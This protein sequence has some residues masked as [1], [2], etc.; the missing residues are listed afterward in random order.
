MFG[1]AYPKLNSARVRTHGLN[2]HI[3][4]ASSQLNVMQIS[5]LSLRE[6]IERALAAQPGVAFY[7]HNPTVRNRRPVAD[8]VILSDCHDVTIVSIDLISVKRI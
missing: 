2:E 8:L 1:V 7:V 6:I 5:K 4:W 3:A